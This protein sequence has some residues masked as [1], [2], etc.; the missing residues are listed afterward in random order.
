MSW[1]QRV[2]RYILQPGYDWLHRFAPALADA[3][4]VGIKKFALWSLSRLETTKKLGTMR[5]QGSGILVDVSYITQQDWGTGIQRVVNNV[6]QHMTELD[7]STC[8]V[9]DRGAR[10][11]TAKAYLARLK[12]SDVRDEDEYIPFQRGDVLFCLDSKIKS[13]K[14]NGN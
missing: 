3:I 4:L 10:L 13:T 9:R 11:V 5:R 12:G 2:K 6:V 8:P 1:R 14:K 7:K